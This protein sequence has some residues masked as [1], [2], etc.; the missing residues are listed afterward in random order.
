MRQRSLLWMIAAR[1]GF[2]ALLPL[3]FLR[4]IAEL[5]L[6]LP[7]TGYQQLMNQW[8]G[9]QWREPLRQ[10]L[11]G[12][13]ALFGL[14]LSVIIATQLIARLPTTRN[15]EYAP[16][17]MTAVGAM[18]H[19][20]I[21][22]ITL[23][24]ISLFEFTASNLAVGIITGLVTA[25]F[26]NWAMKQRW[27][28]LIRLSVDSDNTFYQAMRLTPAIMLSGVLFFIA[29]LLLGSL[30][31]CT[32]IPQSF[33]AW[34]EASDGS[35][36]I[37]GSAMVLLN[38]LLWFIGIHGGVMIQGAFQGVEF[39]AADVA[40]LN[41]GQTLRMIFNSFVLLGGSGSTLGLLIAI[42]IVT[43]Q[44]MQNKIAKISILPS[45]FNIN[46]ILLYGL[47]LVLNPRYLIPFVLV[48]CLLLLITLTAFQT[49]LINLQATTAISWTTPPLIS[50][51][52]LTESWRG[53][54]LQIVLIILSTLCYLPFVKRAQQALDRQ[55]ISEFKEVTDIIV[56]GGNTREKLVT[57][58][59]KTG[60]L[61]R[62]LAVD[63][64][65]AI[66]RNALTLVYQ[67]KHNFQGDIVGVEALLRWTHPRYGMI[68]PIV[69]IA[70]AEDSDLIYH[71][72]RWVIQQA[73][74]C[75]A[76]WNEAGY[77]N[78]TV[79]VNVSPIQLMDEKLPFYLKKYT[80]QYGISAQEI[81]LEITESTEIPDTE[82]TNKILGEIMA[83]G[84]QLSM[85]D[86]GMGYSSLLYLRRFQ[87]AAI[88]IDGSITRDVLSNVTNADIVR[89]IC[90]LGQAQNVHVIAEYVETKEQR[91][92][93]AA[94]G[95]DYFQGYFH[96]PPL[97]EC[98]CVAYLQQHY[99]TA[100]R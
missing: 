72:G 44:G 84:V 67:P 97:S 92:A 32:D 19:Y 56:N 90:S 69:A 100:N 14:L 37:L 68:S 41:N 17:L 96:S 94:M 59:D 51:W 86:F 91:D 57:R 73:C 75:K 40:G 77:Q 70:V 23:P 1:N 62:G 64:H 98:E 36:W 65:D 4:V 45:I 85:D 54:A 34:A 31:Q 11:D 33:V 8:F 7:F 10:F 47:P 12:S 83:T 25:E 99:N 39:V 9:D 58:R 21:F 49:G 30:P 27:L 35:I 60:M 63:M 66:K 78:I 26:I 53:V 95:C 76:R 93:L 55:T 87:V 38:Q 13:F 88:K 22:V 20:L 2:V 50:G 42:F 52:L 80:E 28:N 6:N 43:R 24:G 81:E 61:A 18:V 3:T 29:A 5:I 48:P 82:L 46:D 71:L 74:A 16:P 89:T 15:Q 79:A